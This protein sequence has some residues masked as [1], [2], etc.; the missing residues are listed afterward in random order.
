MKILKKRHKIHPED[1]RAIGHFNVE[2]E[3]KKVNGLFLSV[4]A[5]IWIVGIGT[6]LSGAIGIS[7]IM[8]VVVKERTNEIGIRR[9]IG[10]SPFKIIT[11]V[12]SESIVLTLS[13]GWLGLAAESVLYK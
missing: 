9:A 11:Q 5:L 2:K 1:D 6:L 10:A 8:L 13:A 12:I 7:N 4:A 3:F